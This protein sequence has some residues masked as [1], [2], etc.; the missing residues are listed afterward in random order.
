MVDL[1]RDRVTAN[2]TN[3]VCILGNSG[4]GSVQRGGSQGHTVIIE[5]L[6]RCFG[7]EFLTISR[8]IVAIDSV[9]AVA[10]VDLVGTS[11]AI[12]QV[13]TGDVFFCNS[14]RANQRDAVD[15][16]GVLFADIDLKFQAVGA[17]TLSALHGEVVFFVCC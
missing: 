4:G 16:D 6:D 14:G 17:I 15:E 11:A 9:I 13:V 10:A 8:D 12:D 2:H 5:V 7:A 3:A 1:A